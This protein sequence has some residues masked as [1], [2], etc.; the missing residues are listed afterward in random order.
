MVVGGV[1]VVLH[2]YARLTADVDLVLDLERDAAA[3]AM[4]ALLALGL[5]PRAPVD[6]EDF[7]DERVRGRWLRDEGMQVFSIFKPA[8]PLLSVDVFAEP[9]V[10]FEG[11]YARAEVCDVEAVPVRIASIPD[12]IRLKRLAGR[13]R[14]REDVEKLEEICGGRRSA[15]GSEAGPARGRP[16]RWDAA[17]A[18]V[19]RAQLETMLAAAP[20]ERLAW[21]EEAMRLAHASG[22]LAAARRERFP[23][24]RGSR[25]DSD[26]AGTD[27]D[28]VPKP[29]PPA[30]ERP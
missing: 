27:R 15:V 9:P 2:G 18:D 7:A 16:E 28:G 6:A 3:R 29:S 19:E 21:L 17:W 30:S 13:P 10:D 23:D 14:D 12:L 5:R 11:L 4:R 26:R 20:A 22:A 8:D 1:A 25:S 24:D